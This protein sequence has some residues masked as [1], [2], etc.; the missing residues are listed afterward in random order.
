MQGKARRE[1][2][3]QRL[4]ETDKPLNGT[5]LAQIFD[6]S[7]QVIVQDIAILRAENHPIISTNRGYLLGKQENKAHR[8]FCV[9]HTKE[10]ILEELN[11]IVDDGG[12]VMNTIVEHDVYGQIA[13]EMFLKNRRDVKDF[14]KQ[15]DETQS[16]L[17]TS[18]TNGLHFHTV[19]AESEEDL[20]RI[21]E[22]LKERG[23]YVALMEE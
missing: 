23:F 20:D 10:E 12:Q 6:I 22:S 3:L 14:V 18:L 17:L 9:R 7:R 2:I 4:T 11:L 1:N 15:L 21:E 16:I 13:V 5:E 19:T 8:T